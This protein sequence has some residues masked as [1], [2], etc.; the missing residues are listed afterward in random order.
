MRQLLTIIKSKI[1]DIDTLV[2]YAEDEFL[3][4]LPHTDLKGA[5]HIAER[6]RRDVEEQ[7]FFWSDSQMRLTISAGLASLGSRVTT[8]IELIEVAEDNLLKAKLAGKNRIMK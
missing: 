6:I 7:V 3:I 2:R 8:E 4:V 1:R 5:S